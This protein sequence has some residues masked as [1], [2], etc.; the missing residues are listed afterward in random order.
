MKKKIALVLVAL[1]LLVPGIV[2]CARDSDG[3]GSDLRLTV[4]AGAMEDHMLATLA[5][6]TEQTGIPVYGVRMSAGE[7]LGRIRAERANPQASIWWGGPV[8]AFIQAAYEGLFMEYVSPYAVNIPEGFRCRNNYWTGVYYSFLGFASNQRLLEERGAEAPTSWFD[9]LRP[10]FRGQVSVGDPGATGTAYT[11][12]ATI[13]QIMG[14]EEGL[15]FMAQLD[16]NVRTYEMSGSAPARI[17]GQGEATVSI[18]FLNDAL[19]FREEGFSDL[20]LS[21]P[22]EGTGIQLSAVA[23]ID[24]APDLEAAKIFYDWALGV[25]SQEVGRSLV[26]TMP[27]TVLADASIENDATRGVIAIDYDFVWA[28]EN[29]DRLVAAWQRAVGRD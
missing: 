14:E 22:V 21:S 3:G 8:D 20:V 11:F 18:V 25:D 26:H 28:G 15:E 5:L 1:L 13:L 7:I 2:G 29:R 16:E 4:Y 23:I 24:G 9:L 27:T 12:L 10:E 6:F 17:V 19:T